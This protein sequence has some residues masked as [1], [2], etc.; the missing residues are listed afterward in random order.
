MSK[1]NKDIEDIKL[2]E[3]CRYCIKLE[4]HGGRCSGKTM[5]KNSCILFEK[6]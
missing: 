2:N 4:K 1:S 6:A 5:L 3:E